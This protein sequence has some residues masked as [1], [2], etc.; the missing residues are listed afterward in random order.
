[1]THQHARHGGG[2]GRGVDRAGQAAGGNRRQ[3]GTGGPKSA[4]GRHMNIH[5]STR[6]S[7]G[8]GRGRP[9]QSA[10]KGR[11]RAPA[12]RRHVKAD[13]GGCD[14]GE[15]RGRASVPRKDIRADPLNRLRRATRCSDIG[16]DQRRMH[17]VQSVIEMQRRCRSPD[18]AA[19]ACPVGRA[20]KT[21]RR[22]LV[23]RQRATVAVPGDNVDKQGR[24]ADP[25]LGIVKAKA[26]YAALCCGR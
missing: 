14:I 8:G 18:E 6:V 19:I 16:G 26:A 23:Q 11:S 4:T 10:H 2:R 24:T 15:G 12:R 3:A 22:I 17:G 20:A 9:S 5:L 1:M 13:R 7:D 25:G 21:A